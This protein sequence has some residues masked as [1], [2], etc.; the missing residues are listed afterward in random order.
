M[1]ENILRQEARDADG[2]VNVLD[3]KIV[4][5]NSQ[6]FSNFLQQQTPLDIE[7]RRVYKDRV[8]KQ[9]DQYINKGVT[10]IKERL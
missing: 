7:F 8:E 10:E 4:D 1:V 3:L 6:C 2:N 5:E 9:L